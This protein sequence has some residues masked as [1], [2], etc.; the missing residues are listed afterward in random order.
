MSAT[1]IMQ[2]RAMPHLKPAIEGRLAKME[3]FGDNWAE[4]PVSSF[5]TVHN[6]VYVCSDVSTMLQ[7]DMLQWIIDEA[8]LR[9]DSDVNIVERIFLVNFAA[10]HTSSTVR[11][12]PLALLYVRNL[13]C[14]LPEHDTCIIRPRCPTRVPPA[15]S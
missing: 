10:I 5:K 8:V 4:K 2:D 15:S 1:K 3:E 7:N 9:N 13:R 12:P 11:T 6:L 14:A